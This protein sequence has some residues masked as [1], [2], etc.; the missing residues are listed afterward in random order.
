M[1]KLH[2]QQTSPNPIQ[3]Q[4]ECAPGELHAL[5]GPSGSGKTST[6]RLIAGLQKP[7]GGYIECTRGS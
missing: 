2:I 7:Q 4:L 5:V 6:L 1:L 3:L